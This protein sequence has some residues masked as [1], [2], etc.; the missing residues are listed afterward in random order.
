MVDFYN[1]SPEI[2]NIALRISTANTLVNAFV[3]FQFG[4]NLC[5]L[6]YPLY[7]AGNAPL[8]FFISI[9][10]HLLY[11]LRL[12]VGSGLVTSSEDALIPKTHR[13]YIVNPV[14]VF[15]CFTAICLFDILILYTF[16]NRKQ[17]H[18]LHFLNI[19]SWETSR[20]SQ[21]AS[22]KNLLTI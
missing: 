20:V 14:Q 1:I 19:I 22:N 17:M 2:G 4:I 8:E 15:K 18:Y 6:Y 9:D 10:H 7:T 13:R 3:V 11:I 16:K 5:I 21:G 12:T